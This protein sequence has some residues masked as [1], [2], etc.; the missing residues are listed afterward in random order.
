MTHQGIL[1]KWVCYRFCSVSRWCGTWAFLPEGQAL[2]KPPER[3]AGWGSEGRKVKAVHQ[4]GTCSWKVAFWAMGPSVAELPPG[5]WV[6]SLRNQHMGGPALVCIAGEWDIQRPQQLCQPLQARIR[7]AGARVFSSLPSWSPSLRA[8]CASSQMANDQDGP[9]HSVTIAVQCLSHDGHFLVGGH[10]HM[11][12]KISSHSAHSYM[13]ASTSHVFVSDFLV[14][15]LLGPWPTGQGTDHLLQVCICS[16]PGLHL[17][18]WP[19]S[20]SHCSYMHGSPTPFQ[21]QN[22]H[23]G[24]SILL[25]Q[26]RP[27]DHHPSPWSVCDLRP[28]GQHPPVLSAT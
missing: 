18:A 20:S 6:V 1:G 15:F 8:H 17:P 7:M 3:D 26:E 9:N 13:H 21:C 12:V 5:W 28:L 2:C 10:E 11:I 16:L 24:K 25:Q 14:L 4:I 27:L 23:T 19:W 22:R